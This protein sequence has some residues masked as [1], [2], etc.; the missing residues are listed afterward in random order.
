MLTQVQCPNCNYENSFDL[1]TNLSIEDQA[2]EDLFNGSMNIVI[3]DQCQISFL[4][5]TSLIFR[6]YNAKYYI[7]YMSNEENKKESVLL[8]DMQK[9]LQ[10]LDFEGEEYPELRLT[11]SRQSFIEKIALH[12]EELDDK[13][14]EYLK[15]QFFFSENDLDTK[16][17]DLYYNFSLSNKEMLYFTVFDKSAKKALNDVNIQRNFYEQFLALVESKEK[18]DLDKVFPTY[19]VDQKF[20]KS[21]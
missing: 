5:N 21:I 8:D 4:N 2:L 1:I 18:I 7:Y 20:I 19:I 6:D 15:F 11:L 13:V 3:C 12:I 9:I 10:K 14:I 16:K 17:H